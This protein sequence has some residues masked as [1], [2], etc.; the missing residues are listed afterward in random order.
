MKA[1]TTELDNIQIA[2]DMENKSYSLY[3]S[4]SQTAT[5]GAEREFY[6]ALAAEE[7][8]HHLVLVDYYEYL[9]DPTGWFVTK[10]HPSLDGG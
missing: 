10:E 2:I 1:T 8:G 7:R 5:Y 9:K 4:R 6:N 3:K